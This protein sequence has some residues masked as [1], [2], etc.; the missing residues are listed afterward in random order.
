MIG[1]V[2]IRVCARCGRCNHLAL[3]LVKRKKRAS[4]LI[5]AMTE[6]LLS[7]CAGQAICEGPKE[8]IYIRIYLERE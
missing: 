1:H 6:P 8:N 4:L 2:Y 5:N 3:R 7:L